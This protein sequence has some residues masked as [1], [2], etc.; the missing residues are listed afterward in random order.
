MSKKWD[1]RMRAIGAKHDPVNMRKLASIE[2]QLVCLEDMRTQ[3]KLLSERIKKLNV[4][5]D[6]K[7][8]SFQDMYNHY[9]DLPDKNGLLVL[10]RAIAWVDEPTRSEVEEIERVIAEVETEKTALQVRIAQILTHRPQEHG[11]RVYGATGSNRAQQEADIRGSKRWAERKKSRILTVAEENAIG[12]GHTVFYD[13]CKQNIFAFGNS[14]TDQSEDPVVT[15][16]YVNH[17]GHANLEVFHQVLVKSDEPPSLPIKVHLDALLKTDPTQR[18]LVA[19]DFDRT[20]VSCHTGGTP[21]VKDF[22]KTQTLH[23][24]KNKNA[25]GVIFGGIAKKRELEGVGLL[26]QGLLEQG[27]LV[28]IVTRGIESDVQDVID[29]LLNPDST[30]LTLGCVSKTSDLSL[31]VQVPQDP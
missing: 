17:S 23:R 9:H 10:R 18:W 7:Q 20:L 8:K 6:R 31:R 30:T 16:V 14:Q 12:A 5:R 11:I 13:D 26:L 29:H 27:H 24:L 22:E 1:Y 4:D 25:K 2:T 3:V 28:I 19:F 15:A 21:D